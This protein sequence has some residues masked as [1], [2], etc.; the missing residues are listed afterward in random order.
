MKFTSLA[1][2]AVGTSFQGRLDITYSE[3]VRVFGEPLAEDDGYKVDA[4]WIIEFEN[5]VV[6]TIYNYKSGRNYLGERG[7]DIEDIVFWNIGGFSLEAFAQVS[8]QVC[9]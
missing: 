8:A 4:S 1:R 3:L 2:G 6:A 7:L 5:G 9:E